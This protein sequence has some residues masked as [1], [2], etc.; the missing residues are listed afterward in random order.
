[1]KALI[2]GVTGQDGSLLAKL[3]L[4]KGYEVVGTSRDV[5]MCSRRNLQN[6]GIADRVKITSMSVN[7][8]R[9][10]AHVLRNEEPEHVYNLSGQSSV[11]LSFE[12][13]VEAM[14]SIGSGAL[15]LLEAIR[16]T[17][18]KIKFYNAGSSECFGQTA[19]HGASEDTA[20]DPKSPYGVAKVTAHFLVKNYR[21]AYGLFACTGILFNHE[22]TLRPE[23]FV[24]Q[25]IVSSAAR[26]AKGS[27]E[28]LKLGNLSIHRDWGWAPDY[29]DA[30]HKML[31]QEVPNDYVIA[32]GI[33]ISLEE[34]VKQAFDYFSL[35][36]KNYVDIDAS[37]LRPSDISVSVGN[38][39]KATKDL[40]WS[41]TYDVYGVI[42]AM[43]KGAA[44][45]IHKRSH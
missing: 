24:T 15:N 1:M 45:N 20:F 2:C 34:F 21:E 41:P 22:S 37:L 26:I 14:S 17:N 42:R 11:G 25:K 6:L 12:Q 28:R 9:S 27:N 29:V 32:T 18:Q 40:N 4:E 10:I 16:F 36:W 33:A 8:F 19:G 31:N 23:R 30:M 5:S 39:V 3:L 35:D 43:C 7:D 44:Q 38:A 13:P